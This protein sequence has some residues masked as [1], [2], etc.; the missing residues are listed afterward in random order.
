MC[1]LGKNTGH[2][3]DAEEARIENHFLFWMNMSLTRMENI[4]G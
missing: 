2:L 3:N 1:G 4:G